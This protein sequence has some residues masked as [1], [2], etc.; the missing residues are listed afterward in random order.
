M[1]ISENVCYKY[2]DSQN[3]IL[4]NISLRI[5]P[6]ERIALVGNNGSGKTTLGL[7]LAGIFIPSGGKVLVNSLETD[8]ET[9]R[10]DIRKMVGF[11][12]QNPENQIITT[13][14]ENEL[15]F[16]P[17]NLAFSSNEIN[18]KVEWALNFFNFMNRR[19]VMPVQLSGGEKELLALA[20]I[21]TMDTKFIILDEPTSYL[22]WS[23]KS[24]L[25]GF[26]E[27]LH[28]RNNVGIINITQK[29]DEI[30][31]SDRVIQLKDGEIIY[32]GVPEGIIDT[33]DLKYLSDKATYTTHNLEVEQN[34][35]IAVR[36]R[37]LRFNYDGEFSL[38]IDD[39][40]F[41]KGEPVGI[42]GS[43]GSGKTT[44]LQLLGQLV[45]PIDGNIEIKERNSVLFQFPEK[46]LFTRTVI[47]DVTFG[48]KNLDI[49]NYLEPA[50]EILN[51]L[52]IPEQ[53]FERSPFTLS[54]GEQRKVGIASILATKPEIL[55]LDEPTISL[56]YRSISTLVNV[57]KKLIEE[58]KTIIAAS[59][60]LEFLNSFAKRIIVIQNGKIVFD[61][62][63]SLLF[64]SEGLMRKFNLYNKVVTEVYI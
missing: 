39:L 49:E 40:V 21:L 11:V 61:G 12:F 45:E 53:Y 25:M 56:D 9:N 29:K 33:P 2:D 31:D 51:T 47:D 32:D 5:N 52:G 17:E 36:A 57:C 55:F 1:I 34:E 41:R 43:T 42:V 22:D 30:L 46:Q 28:K 18:E 60:D 10:F 20:S 26:I 23:G 35:D 59:H 3:Y 58:R 13:S 62:K 50:K 6:T 64:S 48:P 7:I 38:N 8:Q 63:K 16:G 54:L 44:L 14:I 24:K 19:N 37:N 15:A 27:E 4:K